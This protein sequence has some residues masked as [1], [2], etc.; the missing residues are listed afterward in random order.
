MPSGVPLEHLEKAAIL[1]TLQQNAGNKTDTA[2]QL[3][4]SVKTLYNKL[5][6]YQQSEPE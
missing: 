4:I 1:N 5:E 6:K 3:G 2:E